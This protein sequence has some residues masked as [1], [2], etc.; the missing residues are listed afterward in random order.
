MSDQ[1]SIAS[2]EVIAIL[3]LLDAEYIEKIPKKFLSVLEKVQDKD[4][5]TNIDANKSILEQNISDKAK[6]IL[7][8]IYRNYWCSEK[9]KQEIDKILNENEK[10]YQQDLR[11]KYNPNDIFHNN[12][13]HSDLEDYI[14][15]KDIKFFKK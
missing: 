10:K 9:E 4:Y 5:K 8:I 1:I 6:D 11:K 2:A 7:I 12:I 14:A 13:N 15:K 3:K